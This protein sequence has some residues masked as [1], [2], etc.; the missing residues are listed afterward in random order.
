MKL[1]EPDELEQ[2]SDLLARRSCSLGDFELHE[3]DVTDPGIDELLPMK[4]YVEV[5]P[6][7]NGTAMEYPTGDGT[8]WVAAFERDLACGRFG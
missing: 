4:G 1:I 8:V 7:S 2:F 6:K 3:A 5:R